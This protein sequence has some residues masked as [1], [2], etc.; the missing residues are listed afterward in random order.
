MG[1]VGGMIELIVIWFFFFIGYFLIKNKW[2]KIKDLLCNKMIVKV[3][4]LFIWELV[5]IILYII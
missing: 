5:V 3:N 4:I 1:I 2:S